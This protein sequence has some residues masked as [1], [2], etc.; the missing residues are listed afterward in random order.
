MKSLLGIL[1]SLSILIIQCA[2]DSSRNSSKTYRISKIT[3]NPSNGLGE[4][5]VFFAYDTLGRIVKENYEVAYE[6]G[7][8][9]IP[10]CWSYQYKT[11]KIYGVAT[12]LK[13]TSDSDA[14]LSHSLENNLLKNSLIVQ[15]GV[16]TVSILF[17]YENNYID[18]IIMTSK[19]VELY[20][21]KGNISLAKFFSKKINE[22]RWILDRLFVFKY[23]TM[24]NNVLGLQFLLWEPTW[25]LNYSTKPH[26]KGLVSKNLPSEVK[27]YDYNEKGLVISNFIEKYHYQHNP[28]D[29]TD[30][31]LIRDSIGELLKTISF[32]YER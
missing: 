3:V 17:L 4:I 6:D 14:E 15:K 18:E 20:W 27:I 7:Y 5:S 24:Q 28:N 21:Q 2:Y 9:L 22:D 19:R 31:I 8:F 29:S 16:D 32:E 25:G 23:N 11:N 13:S 12:L 30:L 10:Y 26:Q 1:L